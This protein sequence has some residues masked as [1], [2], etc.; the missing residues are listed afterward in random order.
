MRLNLWVGVVE[1][2]EETV[3][4]VAEIG[5]VKVVRLGP[6]RTVAHLLEHRNQRDARR[7]TY[8][9]GSVVEPLG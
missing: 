8:A 5:A 9:V 1:V 3:H 6:R 7:D 4:K 2:D